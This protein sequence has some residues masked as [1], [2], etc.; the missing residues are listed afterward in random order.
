MK[1]LT[2]IFGI[3]FCANAIA[4]TSA[5]DTQIHSWHFTDVIEVDSTIKKDA[6]FRKARQWFSTS[7]ESAKNVID[8]ADQEE[9]V[10]YGKGNIQISE[11]DGFV[12]FNIELRCKDGR[13]KYTLSNFNHKNA[14]AVNIFGAAITSGQWASARYDF[15]ALTKT[16][17]M[18]AMKLGGRKPAR[19]EE[20]KSIAR[21][22][23]L[24]F[25]KN[26]KESMTAEKLKSL[27]DW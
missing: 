21:S 1:K 13:L 17:H 25:I 16:E 7:F 9:G 11:A 18:S 22:R 2:V 20:M 14:R 8:N 23:T 19:W 10:I 4:Q 24:S 15:G 5:N 3:I 26:L 27:D 12:E 6:L